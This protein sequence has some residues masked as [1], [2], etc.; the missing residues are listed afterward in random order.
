MP[1]YGWSRCI[2][3]ALVDCWLL[4]LPY[5]PRRHRA[6]DGVKDAEIG[7]LQWTSASHSILNLIIDHLRAGPAAHPAYV[8]G[9][10]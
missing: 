10:S 1:I 9:P 4:P 8:A 3:D 7:D 5:W 6:S 2:G